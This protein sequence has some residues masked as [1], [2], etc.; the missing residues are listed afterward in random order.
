MRPALFVALWAGMLAVFTAVQFLFSGLDWLTPVL[1]G[2]AAAGTLGLAA[3]V[4]LGGEPAGPRAVPDHS[5]AT[6]AVAGG[7]AAMVL[8]AEAGPWLIY[9][10][11]GLTV[12]GLAG[13]IRERRAVRRQPQRG[14]P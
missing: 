2:W 10:G 9:L 4:A 13:L 3:V 8:G 5:A 11:A 6:V 14:R 12:F 7:V 1:L